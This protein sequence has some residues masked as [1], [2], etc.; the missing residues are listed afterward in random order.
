MTKLAQI[1]TTSA[2][3]K[4]QIASDNALLKAIHDGFEL[5]KAAVLSNKGTIYAAGNGGSACDAM[6]FVEELVA[7][8]KATRPGIRAM[9]FADPATV[10]CWSNDYEY[11]GVFQRYAETF[12][13]SSDVFVAISTSGNSE[14]ILRAIKSAK[15]KGTRIIGLSGQTGGKM[16]ELCDVIIKVPSAETAR[17][18]ESHITIIHAWCELFDNEFL[19]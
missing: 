13:T 6:H 10:T 12:C 5:L 11:N 1:F 18:Q 2:E 14:N 8:Y 4:K 15:A 7:R 19:A 17:I 16:S 9:H 3:V